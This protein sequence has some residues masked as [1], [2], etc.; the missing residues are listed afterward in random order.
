MKQ[1]NL[2]SIL[3]LC[4]SSVA[5]ATELPALPHQQKA[6][7]HGLYL[8]SEQANHNF[9]SWKID[10]GYSYNVFKDIDLYVGAR[11][12]KSNSSDESG[13]I[14]G[15]SY[16]VNNRVSVKS[17]LHSYTETINNEKLDTLSAEVSS[18]VRLTENVDLHATLDYQEW[19]QGF[20]VGLGFRF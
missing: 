15:V 16:Q 20:E 7:P 3:F 2:I 12:D 10:G 19:Q 1:L 17:T 14:S 13:L 6:S 11:I 8:S 4:F 9:D 18:R 5:F